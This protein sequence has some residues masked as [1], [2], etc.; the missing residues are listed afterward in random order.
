MNPM[1]RLLSLLL[2][3]SNTA[4]AAS[5]NPAW[6]SIE[7]ERT[8]AHNP[9]AGATSI[10]NGAALVK[11]VGALQPGDRLEIGAGSYSVE[12]MWDVLVSGT[13]EAPIWIVAAKDAQVV[14]TRPDNKQNVLNLGQGG[15]V[16][17]LCLRGLEFTGGSHGL[18]L[19]Q[20]R[21]VWV[22]QCH[23]HHTNEVCLSANSA[24][25]Q[26]LYLTR[27]HI[28]HG[29]GHAEGMYL[30]GNNATHIMS[31]SVIAQN[32]I[33]DCRGD[34]GDGIE[35]KQGSWGN[36]IAENHVHDTNYP[37]I[38]VYGTNGQPVNIIERNLCYRSGDSVMQV[39]GEAIVR[40][41]VLIAGKNGGFRSTD[42]QGKTLNLQVIHNTIINTSHAFAGGSWNGREGMIL[43]NNVLYSR[44][45]NA[46]HFA[47]GNAGVT[48][49][50][51][52]VFGDG[53]KDGCTKGRGLEDFRNLTWDA[54]VHDATPTAD[55]PLEN[56]DLKFLLESDFNHNAREGMKTSGAVAR[57]AL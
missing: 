21:D 41:N 2:L 4:Q 19:G 23:I 11:A 54:S 13:A 6:A 20:C 26:R 36:L 8:I 48:S 30:G 15:P 34:Q 1:I 7:P 43:A 46:L 24:D 33:H 51:N 29:G 25:T 38:T 3:V 56:A 31:H 16:S 53:P 49:A 10:Q 44:D 45:A 40:N 12:R 17:F 55:A 22:D 5:Y 14:I 47:N 27:N 50:G 35:V 52:V 18:R 37:C 57:Q 28:H 32:H 9:L 42:H 39:Q